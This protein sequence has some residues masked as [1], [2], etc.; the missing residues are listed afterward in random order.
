MRNIEVL[1]CTLRDGG[2]IIDCEFSDNDIRQIADGLAE[3]KVDIVEMGFLRDA[4]YV[5]YRGNS[6]FFTDVSQI[7]PF[8]HRRGRTKYT[9]FI[10]FGMY[11]FDK[12]DI[13]DGSSVDGIRVGFTKKDLGSNKDELI[14]CMDIV[15]QKGYALYVQ[16]VNTL[17]YSDKEVLE[18]VDLVNVLNPYSFG[19]VDTY[20]AMYMEDLV[21]LY[22][23]IDHNLKSDIC[24]DIHSHN[25]FQ[26]SF[27]FA[28]EAIKLSM[29]TRRV[30]LDSTLNGMGK[31]A[32][33][34][35]TELIVDYLV[36]KKNYDYEFDSVLDIIDEYLYSIKQKNEWGYS[37]P[38]FMAGIYKA[39][40]NN[41]I[42][43]TEKF[44]LDT[45][46]IRNIISMIDEDTRQHYDY[47]NIEKIY[48]E[49][50]KSKVDDGAVIQYL[51]E[52]VSG[53][54]VLILVPGSSLKNYDKEIKDFIEAREP[55]IFSV[56]FIPEYGNGYVFWGNTK[57][58]NTC[59]EFG[60]YESVLA[61]NVNGSYDEDK[62][63]N[64]HSL[65]NR[66]YKYFDNTTMMLLNLMKRLMPDRLVIA[67]FDGFAVEKSNNYF[68]QA[69]KNDRYRTEYAQINEELY[70]MLKAYYD[71]IY[72]KYDVEFL[73]PSIFEGA[74]SR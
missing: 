38:S 46:D 56:N 8:I 73:T 72:D 11:D 61:S 6:T 9:A 21:R 3:A 55:I 43:L 66:G 65:I 29:G 44:R 17:G 64:Y 52:K 28:Q 25:N 33:N 30:I 70:K 7:V 59:K 10:D 71:M 74:C 62:I 35:N 5:I 16:G 48:I 22:N 63:V 69:L 41:V 51:K 32:G 14:K 49:Y 24:I 15:K 40:P 1:D 20:G 42:Y 50:G 4:S 45:K 36:R 23:L 57:R 47:E 54:E 34:L 2:R 26:L 27:A 18:L 39:H 53:K 68:S 13:C 19:I 37:I 12:L 31:C 67:G 60:K 58:Y